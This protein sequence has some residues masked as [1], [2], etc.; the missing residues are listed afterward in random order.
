MIFFFFYFFLFT[1]STE[2][3]GP[4]TILSSNNKCVCIEGFM[5]GDPYS[6]E[7]CYKCDQKCHKH[8]TCKYPGKCVCSPP[9]HGDG[10]FNCTA[11]V[12][13]LDLVTPNSGPAQ[14]GTTILIYYT[15][16][17]NKYTPDTAF[18]KFGSEI[19]KSESITNTTITCITPKHAPVPT[20][21]SI[22][23]DS[24]S[25]SEEK[26]FFNFV[27]FFIDDDETFENYFENEK[28]NNDDNDD[29]D[30]DDI[31]KEENESY[32]YNFD[33]KVILTLTIMFL[34]LFFFFSVITNGQPHNNEL[35]I[36]LRKKVEKGK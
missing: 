29:D 13:Q 22:S 10:I 36:A 7:G 33:Y 28:E 26:I 19:V 35:P 11:D 27:D 20:Y 30:D 25:W 4:N 16:S 24:I 31:K 9:Y 34:T 18:C 14:G 21:L 3:K 12:P 23:F 17:D 1:T 5:Y 2:C 8:S 6:K 15:Y 32:H